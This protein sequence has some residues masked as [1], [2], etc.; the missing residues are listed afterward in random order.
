MGYL[1]ASLDSGMEL[2]PASD[3]R[4]AASYGTPLCDVTA[5][6]LSRITNG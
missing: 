4:G 3:E 2:L 5:T 6:L 1:K